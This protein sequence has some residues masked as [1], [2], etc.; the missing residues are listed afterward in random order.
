MMY[1]LKNRALE[2]DLK[3]ILTNNIDITKGTVSGNS[4][5]LIDGNSYVS[6]PY[7]GKEQDRDF[8]FNALNNSIN[9][10]NDYEG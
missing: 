5:E 8:D 2:K 9:K 4:I 1:K 3:D 7:Y 6:Y 10:I